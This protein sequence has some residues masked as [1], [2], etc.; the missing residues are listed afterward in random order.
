MIRRMG[1]MGI[2]R[3]MRIMGIMRIIKKGASATKTDFEFRETDASATNRE[4]FL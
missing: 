2:R 1:I 3:V 4:H